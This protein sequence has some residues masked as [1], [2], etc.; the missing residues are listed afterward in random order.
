LSCAVRTRPRRTG[1]Q[2]PAFD[3]IG[4]LFRER[5][6]MFSRFR[7]GSELARVNADAAP[8]VRVSQ[9]FCDAVSAALQAARLT[10]GLVDPTVGAAIEAAGY[11]IDFDKLVPDGRPVEP[12]PCD[13]WR[14]IRVGRG[15]LI[16]PPGTVLDL[17]GVVKALAVDDAVALLAAPGFV[18]AGGDMAT[19]AS[20]VTVALPDGDAIALES[21]GIATSGTTT[22]RWLRAGRVQH[23]LIDPRSGRPSSSPWKCVTAVGRDC[24]GADIAAKAGFLL[25][26]DGPR[27][28]DE[29]G[30]AARFITE[31]AVY[32]NDCWAR[33]LGRVTRWA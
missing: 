9:P 21:G 14:E 16:R 11:D 17:N 18:S 20:P 15:L 32:E 1:A 12:R 26:A 10:D 8:V 31:G 28:L 29:R 27:W 2:Q 3:A 19:R 25:G 5:D 23:H 24:F 33:S 13:R 7:A 22:R 30:V 4:Q 6:A